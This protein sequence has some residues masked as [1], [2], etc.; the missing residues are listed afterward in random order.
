M[1][2]G[3]LLPLLVVIAIQNM[4]VSAEYAQTGFE[5]DHEKSGGGVHADSN[6]SEIK[7]NRFRTIKYLHLAAF[8][9]FLIQVIAYGAIKVDYTIA[10]TS[11]FPIDCNS[12]EPPYPTCYGSWGNTPGIQ[13]YERWNPLW[14]ITLFIAL[15]CFDHLVSFLYC[16]IYEENAKWW[17]YVAGS[18]PFRWVEYSVSASIMAWGISILCGIQDVHLWFLIL[19]GHAIGMLLGQ[20]GNER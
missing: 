15:A 8:F 4:S 7:P 19:F 1:E 17:I 16:H 9:F 2:E 20:V 5:K 11:G 12:Y 6:D 10:S 13:I 3:V 14:I 18:N